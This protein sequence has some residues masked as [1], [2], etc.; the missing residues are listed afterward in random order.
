MKNTKS[1]TVEALVEQSEVLRN[2]VRPVESAANTAQRCSKIAARL[3]F[4]PEADEASAA[5]IRA[6]TARLRS[7]IGNNRSWQEFAEG[8][9]QVERELIRLRE[10]S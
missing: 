5:K 4:E 6:Q 3:S 2:Y 9:L 10:R 7:A 1:K 8:A